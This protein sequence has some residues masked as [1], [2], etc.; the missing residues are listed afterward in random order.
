MNI[1]ERA[2]ILT[3]MAFP[4]GSILGILI[5]RLTAAPASG[6][7]FGDIIYIIM[8]FIFGAPLFASVTYFWSTRRIDWERPARSRAALTMAK[9]IF[10]ATGVTIAL[11]FALSRGLGSGALFI[12][13]PLGAL[14]VTLSA[15][16]ALR[17]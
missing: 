16:K 2:M 11:V 6:G 9:G 10:F 15:R 13:L 17:T 12:G 7:G 4:L 8:W 1:R 3:G 5:G 14:I